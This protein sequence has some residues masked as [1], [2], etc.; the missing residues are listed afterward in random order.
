MKIDE[1]NKFFIISDFNYCLLFYFTT[2]FQLIPLF[3][4]VF[5]KMSPNGKGLCEVRAT[6]TEI[7]EENRE[8]AKTFSIF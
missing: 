1:N 6:A 4:V 2:F 7:G 5:Y 3:I 8:L